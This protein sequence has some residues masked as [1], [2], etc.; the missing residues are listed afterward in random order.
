[1]FLQR[2][3]SAKF[4]NY[5]DNSLSNHLAHLGK[6]AASAIANAVTR[7]ALSKENFGQNLIA[8]IPD[9][10]GQAIF[11]ALRNGISL[12][13]TQV[14]ETPGGGGGASTVGNMFAQSTQFAAGT[15]KYANLAPGTGNSNTLAFLSDKDSSAGEVGVA[16]PE[17]TSEAS[18]G[19]ELIVTGKR[20]RSNHKVGYQESFWSISQ[21][22]GISVA[23]IKKLN[24]GVNPKA[25]PIGTQLNLPAYEIKEGDLWSE[26]LDKLADKFNTTPEQI[27]KLNGLNI[28]RTYLGRREPGYKITFEDGTL[29]SAGD[30]LVIN[31]NGDYSNGDN[32]LTWEEADRHARWGQKRAV[33]VDASKLKFD[34]TGS[35]ANPNKIPVNIMPLPDYAVH[36]QATVRLRSNGTYGIYDGPYNFE[37]HSGG[38][39]GT[40]I[41]NI[42]TAW[43][44][45]QTTKFG[46]EPKTYIIEYYGN[47]KKLEPIPLPRLPRG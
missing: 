27:A 1:M 30:K 33:R 39:F 46:V 26:S 42:G 36:G 6:G 3:M 32:H 29:I 43:G 47:A 22:Y 11:D 7:S 41:R 4:R 21:H 38:G 12:P 35:T 15:G 16:T 37:P 31:S 34:I 2:I 20:L 9:V 14:D 8:A 18:K 17:E 45:Q 28:E 40:M 5:G 44:K 25:I 19:E 13:K 24:K 10:I 23:Q